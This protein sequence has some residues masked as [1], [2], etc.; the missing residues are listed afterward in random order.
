MV[1]KG[2]S[3][4]EEMPFRC[5]RIFF[6]S[7]LVYYILYCVHFCSTV[8]GIY[9]YVLAAASLLRFNYNIRVAVRLY[10]CLRLL[11]LTSQCLMPLTLI[12]YWHQLNFPM[13]LLFFLLIYLIFII[14]FFKLLGRCNGRWILLGSQI[15]ALFLYLI[16]LIVIYHLWSWIIFNKVLVNLV[17]I[18]FLSHS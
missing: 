17:S 1:S 15:M 4:P 12:Q 5:L 2:K 6:V 10:C 18:D 14:R 7:M 8:E 11:N 9:D 13:L 3:I 16:S